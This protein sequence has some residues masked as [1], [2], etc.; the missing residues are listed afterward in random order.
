MSRAQRP[1]DSIYYLH[2]QALSGERGKSPPC[3]Y[4]S[5][6]QSCSRLVPH[7]RSHGHAEAPASPLPACPTLAANSQT[8]PPSTTRSKYNFRKMLT[9]LSIMVKVARV[10]AMQISLTVAATA[11]VPSLSAQWLQTRGELR[12]QVPGRGPGSRD[13]VLLG[14]EEQHGRWDQVRHSP[15]ASA[16][17]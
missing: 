15:R 8:L 3:G 14:D 6:N 13:P 2:L 5:A 11:Y 16:F 12:H 7:A 9:E 10:K 17:Y 1:K 4:P